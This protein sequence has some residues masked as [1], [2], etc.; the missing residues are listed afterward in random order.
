MR[1]TCKRCESKRVVSIIATPRAVVVH[2]GDVSVTNI[3]LV[4][5]IT[6]LNTGQIAFELCLECGQVQ[7][8]W[9]CSA[10]EL[11]KEPV[12]KSSEEFSAFKRYAEGRRKRRLR[13]FGVK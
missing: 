12:S 13:A 6:D 4:M 5:G 1:E 7:G 10:T 9:P 8:N 11:D 2:R 3:P